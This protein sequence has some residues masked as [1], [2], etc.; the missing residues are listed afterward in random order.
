MNLDRGRSAFA[1]QAWGEAFAHFSA[2]DRE[3]PLDPW[4]LER[5]ATAAFLVGRE[6]ESADIWARAHHEFLKGGNA[7]RAARCAFWAGFELMDRGETAR[8][9]GW[10]ARARRLLDDYGRECAEQGYLLLPVAM[11]QVAERKVQA[12]YDTFAHAAEIGDRLGDLDLATMARHGQGRALILLGETAQGVA[13]LDEVMIAVTGGEVFPPLV[14]LVYC[15]VISACYEMF[16]LRR[17]QEWTAA[18]SQWCERQ[19]DLVPYRGTCLVRR[20]EIMQ[21][22]GAWQDA[23]DEVKRACDRL[24]HPPGQQGVGAAFYQQAELH[25]LRGEFDQAEDAYRQASQFGRKPEPGL[26]L[27]RLAQGQVEVASAAIRRVVSET[28][29][30][31]ARCR[32]L[33]AWVE[34]ALAA[35]DVAGARAAA[36][37]LSD[38]AAGRETSFLRAVSAQAAGTVLVAEGSV[39]PGLGALRQAWNEWQELGAPYEAARVRV[40]IGLACRAVGDSDAA[41]LEFDAAHRVFEELGAAPDLGRLDGLAREAAPEPAGG[42]TARE[43]QV[44]RLIATGKTN[45]A[46]A[47]ELAISEKTVARHV[48]NIFT[49]LGLSS[50]AAATAYAYQHRILETA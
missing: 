34:I 31:P 43:L 44:L 20:A 6:V 10:F 37:E 19:P 38:L 45:R 33:A 12:A 30:P 7:I 50:R 14:G 27:L 2:A 16:D 24:V 39:G 46:I 18:L 23:M 49:K 25:R 29:G 40:S 35:G 28:A 1:R 21:L 8:A 3:T 26:A 9:S 48:S 32:A 5:L 42:L 15:S 36:N 11:E 47:G 4:D 22:H 17:A 41:E 13:L